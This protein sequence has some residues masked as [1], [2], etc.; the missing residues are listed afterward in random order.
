MHSH[1]IAQMGSKGSKLVKNQIQDLFVFIF[2]V[3]SWKSRV[4]YCYSVIATL[5]GVCWQFAL[6]FGHKL[7]KV[8]HS[9]E[10]IDCIREEII[11]MSG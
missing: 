10:S 7:L 5:V 1:K 11:E 8:G 6:V 9:R 3:K 4:N 2:G